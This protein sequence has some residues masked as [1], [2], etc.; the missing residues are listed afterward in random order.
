LKG[1]LLICAIGHTNQAM[2]S[3]SSKKERIT[4]S[5]KS[6]A[7][8]RKVHKYIRPKPADGATELDEARE[9]AQARRILQV[10][11]DQAGTLEHRGHWRGLVALVEIRQNPTL[12]V[13]E[14]TLDEAECRKGYDGIAD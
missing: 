8:R 6:P 9:V 1:R 13:R 14:G 3:T 5:L 7:W 10:A 12:G 11:V 4:P 2:D